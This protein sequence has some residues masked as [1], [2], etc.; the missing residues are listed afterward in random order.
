MIESIL[1]FL[2]S[3]YSHFLVEE[4][5]RNSNIPHVFLKP[6]G[7]VPVLEALKSHKDFSFN[8]LNDLTAVDWLG[9]KKIRFEVLY[10]IRS[11]KNK[12]FQLQ[13]RVPID[14]GDSV[15]SIVSV[16]KGA[17]W[18]ERE[19]YD[20]FGIPFINHP[21]LERI[22]LPDNFVGYPLRKDYPLE[23]PGQDYLIQDL[24]Q[25]HIQD[26]ISEED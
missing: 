21:N 18:P 26:D 11:P 19:I 6:E 7:I 20:L 2:K 8:Y 1:T 13:L 23:G 15:P 10:L 24:L 14:E 16:F 25:I 3:N 17:N 4:E 12:H 22:V 5:N 9:K